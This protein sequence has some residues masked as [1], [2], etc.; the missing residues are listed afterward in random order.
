MTILHY[1]MLPASFS[2]TLRQHCAT[3]TA[4]RALRHW[5]RDLF[6]VAFRSY[7]QGV[8]LIP[9]VKVGGKPAGI[10]AVV[11]AVIGLAV[12]PV[13]AVAAMVL[14]G[15]AWKDA[16]RWARLTLIAGAV[17]YV[18]YRVGGKHPAVHHG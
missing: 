4:W 2:F 5:Q 9:K 8:A 17:L 15:V 10:F 6:G 11:A 13:L 3:D 14:A 16:P 7:S 18:A 1:G 12:I